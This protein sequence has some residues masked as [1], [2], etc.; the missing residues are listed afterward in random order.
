MQDALINGGLSD[1][2]RAQLL[3]GGEQSEPYRDL[4]ARARRLEQVFAPAAVRRIPVEQEELKHELQRL[5]GVV[6]ALEQK[7]EAL[8]LPRTR[9]G[10]R[11]RSD[12]TPDSAA[13]AKSS[14]LDARKE[15]PII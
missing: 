1:T 8:S 3:L 12:R 7:V 2:L 9:Y 4:I 14:D 6:S 10:E 15:K 13:T 11:R 5:T